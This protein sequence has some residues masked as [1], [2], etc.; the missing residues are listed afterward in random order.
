MSKNKRN[1]L[2]AIILSIF[3]L[4]I[5]TGRFIQMTKNHQANMPIMEGCVDNG[6]TLIVSQKHLLALKTATCEE[7]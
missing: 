1:T 4:A 5:G 2:I 3:I 6:G 7:N